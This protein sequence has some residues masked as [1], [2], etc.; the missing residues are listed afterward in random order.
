MDKTISACVP[1]D[2][3][4]VIKNLAE[5]EGES[6]SGYL[7]KLLRREISRAESGKEE[8]P[9]IE[10]IL[11]LLWRI[12][13]AKP[14]PNPAQN[15]DPAMAKKIEELAGFQSTFPSLLAGKTK[16]IMDEIGKIPKPGAGQTVGG[17]A[18]ETGK[19]ILGKLNDLKGLMTEK[20]ETV[21]TIVSSG[22]DRVSFKN[23]QFWKKSLAVLVLWSLIFSVGNGWGMWKIYERGTV[24]AGE[25]G[26]AMADPVWPIIGHVI[27]C[28]MKGW[29]WKWDENKKNVLCVLGPNPTTG[30]PYEVRIQ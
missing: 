9:K 14:V 27:H 11:T 6:V 5:M 29:T 12:I 17:I 26:I 28:D 15:Y 3:H 24:N 22:G 10:E 19:E 7:K 18:P 8:D 1:E 30:K 20:S 25:I 16:E 4:L 13:E 2:E 21:G 23:P